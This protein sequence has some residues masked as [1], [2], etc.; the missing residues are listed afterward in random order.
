MLTLVRG[1]S[2]QVVELLALPER[3]GPAPEAQSC[4]RVLDGPAQIPIAPAS[5]NDAA[6]GD[7]QP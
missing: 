2:V 3:R 1:D 5:I 4:Y 7:L 6:E